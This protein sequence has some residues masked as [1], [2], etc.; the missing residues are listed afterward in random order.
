MNVFN[1]YSTFTYRLCF[2]FLLDIDIID[3]RI[4]VNI[5]YIFY[6]NKKYFIRIIIKNPNLHILITSILFQCFTDLL[7]L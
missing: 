2:Y 1:F 3:T 5:N 6:R 4:A 7:W